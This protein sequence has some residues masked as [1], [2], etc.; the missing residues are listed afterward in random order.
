[1]YSVY[2]LYSASIDKFYI[3][4]SSDV[5]LRLDYHNS[6]INNNWTKRGRPWELY[7]KMEGMSKSQ[8]LQIEKHIKKM[9]SIK[10]ISNLVRYPEMQ[11]KLFERYS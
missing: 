4:Y 11:E 10:Y 6:L 1:M 2:I 7:F 3:G 9:K 5:S 8:A